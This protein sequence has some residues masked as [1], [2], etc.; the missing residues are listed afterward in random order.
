VCHFLLQDQRFLSVLLRIDEELAAGRQAEGCGCGGTLHVAHYPRKPRG[1]PRGAWGDDI[2]R[3]S[4]C[5]SGCRAR[6]TPESVRFL[7]RRVWLALVVVLASP[8]SA[9]SEAMCLAQRLSVPVRT[10]VRWQQWWRHHFPQTR[11]WQS[12]RARFMPPLAIGHLPESLVER[13]QTGV[14]TESMTRL[15]GFLSPLTAGIAITLGEGR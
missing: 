2:R 15:L 5:C 6:A 8:R 3:F 7:G 13:F 14:A 12:A 9:K 11:F 1:L 4:F 10:L